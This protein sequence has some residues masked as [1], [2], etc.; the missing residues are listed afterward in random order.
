MPGGRHVQQG[1]SYSCLAPGEPTPSPPQWE[2][3]TI[4]GLLIFKPIGKLNC[5]SVRVLLGIF[6][7]E[8]IEK[9]LFNTLTKLARGHRSAGASPCLLLPTAQ[10][11]MSACP[12]PTASWAPFPCSEGQYG[13]TSWTSN[14]EPCFSSSCCVS[15]LSPGKGH[16]GE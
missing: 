12:N 5:V 1:C 13:Y 9:K 2:G 14:V 8:V 3:Q 16:L 6:K 15:W 11:A 4:T 7:K 10:V